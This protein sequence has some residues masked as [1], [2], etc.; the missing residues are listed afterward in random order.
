MEEART[1]FIPFWLGEEIAECLQTA[2]RLFEEE[3]YPL[4]DGNFVSTSGVSAQ[5]KAGGRDKSFKDTTCAR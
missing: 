5:E 2:G 4:P 1:E 3:G